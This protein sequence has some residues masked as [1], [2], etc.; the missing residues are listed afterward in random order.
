MGEIIMMNW[1][2]RE[3]GVQVSWPSL[4]RQVRI[5]I[6]WVL[7]S[8]GVL[9]NPIRQVVH[10]ISHSP[11]YP[12]Y[13]SHPHPPSCAF[14]STT[15]PSSHEHKVKSSLS[16]SPCHH[17]ELMLS[18]A[19]TECSIHHVQHT[20]CAAY[21]LCSIYRV[22]HTLCSAYTKWSIHQV[23]HRPEIVCRPLILTISSWLLN[24]AAASG[25]PPYWSTATSQF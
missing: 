10:L 7:T 17:H 16:I 5:P 21:T 13:H 20:P 1:D 11:S 25:I 19:Y 2:L 22:Q 6:W 8:I 15:L 12:P 14:S 23:Q 9:L 3:V 4:I 18:A 24:V